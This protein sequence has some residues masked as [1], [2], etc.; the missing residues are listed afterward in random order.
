[1]LIVIVAF[2]VSP[3]KIA[4]GQTGPGS[5]YAKIPRGAYSI[6][7]EVYAKTG[8]REALRAATAN[9]QNSVMI[10]YRA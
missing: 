4:I 6:I 5:G 1:M 7:A 9:G 3:M 2:C 10:L 8:K